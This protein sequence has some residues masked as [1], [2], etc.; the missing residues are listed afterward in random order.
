MARYAISQEGAEAMRLLSENLRSILDGL[1]QSSKGLK[2]QIMNY[3]DELGVYGIEIWS[4]ALNIDNILEDNK[5]SINELANEAN[6][7]S[8]EIFGLLDMNSTV[9][10]AGGTQGFSSS[11][12]TVKNLLDTAGVGYNSISSFGR[13]RT[14]SEIVDRLGGGDRTDGSCSSLAF[15][16]TGNK[17]GYDVLDFRG[18]DS[19]K[20][21][22]SNASIQMISKL[23]GVNSRIVRGTDDIG[24][25][26]SLLQGMEIGKEYYLATGMHASIV[27]N[28]DGQLEFLELQSAKNNGWHNLDNGILQYRFGC[29]RQNAVEYPNFLIDV[30][31]LAGSKDFLDLLGYI[32]TEEPYLGNCETGS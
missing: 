16:Y 32:N 29:E 17:A 3:M 26:N 12:D 5:D 31:S 18:G 8:A 27:R 2:N 6:K 4:M 13:D 9:S 10:D 15:A 25:A 24:C 21:F 23:P 7:K 1:E 20:F 22:S 30:D 11:H 28:N 19:R 14:T